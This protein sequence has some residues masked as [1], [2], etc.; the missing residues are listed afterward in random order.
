MLRH[1]MLRSSASAAN[2]ESAADSS[3]TKVSRVSV[4]LWNDKSLSLTNRCF[5][6]ENE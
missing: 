4:C 1:V 2:S 5:R 3:S 6:E